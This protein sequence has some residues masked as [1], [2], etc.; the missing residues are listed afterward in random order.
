MAGARI[1]WR[2]L[3]SGAAR[4]VRQ[5]TQVLPMDAANGLVDVCVRRGGAGDVWVD[6]LFD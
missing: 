5:S 2:L 3:I 1:E 6:G 4:H